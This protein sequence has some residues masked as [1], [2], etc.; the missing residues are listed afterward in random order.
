MVLHFQNHNAILWRGE[1]NVKYF[2]NA[3][4]FS[5]CKIG[6]IYMNQD[7]GTPE[8]IGRRCDISGIEVEP[9]RMGTTGHQGEI[10]GANSF[11]PGR[12]NRDG[13][14][15]NWKLTPIRDTTAGKILERL[16]LLEKET[17]SY[18][19]SHQARLEARLGE[20]KQTEEEFIKESNQI[21]SDIYHLAVAQQNSNGN[22]TN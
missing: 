20:S 2:G 7:Y 5:L 11:F 9:I 17:L 18:I 16:E 13:G 14:D 8:K 19:R 4:L 15:I 22:G 21:K 12:K 10:A 3:I 6:L 1:T